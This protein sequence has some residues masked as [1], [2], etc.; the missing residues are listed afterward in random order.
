MQ[1]DTTKTCWGVDVELHAFLTSA[2]YRDEWLGL[3]P[4]PLDLWEC[5]LLYP[6]YVGVEGSHS[7]RLTLNKRNNFSQT[8]MFGSLS[9]TYVTVGCVSA[10]QHSFS[11][12]AS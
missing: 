2:L 11:S 1:S 7:R 4:W 12:I 6:L 5:F 9:S 10:L 8:C 3:T